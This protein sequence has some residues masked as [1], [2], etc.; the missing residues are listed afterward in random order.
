MT[1]V[2]KIENRIRFKIKGRRLN[3]SLVFVA[4]LCFKIPKVVTLNSTQFFFFIMKIPIK[5]E[6][7]QIAYSH[8]SDNDSKDFMNLFKKMYCKTIFF[9]SYWLYSCIRSFFAFQK[10]SFGKNIKT[11]HD[12]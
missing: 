11:N 4:Q 2:N 3:I 12:S 10:E 9:C 8:S 7:E 1:Y 5:K 6:L